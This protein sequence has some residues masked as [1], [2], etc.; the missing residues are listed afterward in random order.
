MLSQAP[1]QSSLW[2]HGFWWALLLSHLLPSHFWVLV[3]SGTLGYP[4]APGWPYPSPL[5]V[6]TLE[7]G[8]GAVLSP[9]H[10]RGAFHLSALRCAQGT[11]AEN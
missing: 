1:D 7:V 6:D 9:Q 4:T 10:V 8:E 2:F 3:P 11:R 5:I